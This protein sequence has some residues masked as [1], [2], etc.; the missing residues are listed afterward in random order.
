[1]ESG[2]LLEV[3]EMLFSCLK[4][5]HPV[6]LWVN[7]YLC[8]LFSWCKAEWTHMGMARLC[9]GHKILATPLPP[10]MERGYQSGLRWYY[11]ESL[12]LLHLLLKSSLL[13]LLIAALRANDMQK[14]NKPSTLLHS[15]D[16]DGLPPAT[17]G[18]E[19]K[20]NKSSM[21]CQILDLPTE[22]I[23]LGWQF[24]FFSKFS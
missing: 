19:A 15:F 17:F 9:R 12:I 14:K 18:K 11:G 8:Q 13:K 21:E 24:S 6:A 7:F 22:H 20:Q 2:G 4:L 5:S 23:C 1:M 3:K 10:G 16:P